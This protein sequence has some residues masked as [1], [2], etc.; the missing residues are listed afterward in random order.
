MRMPDGSEW[1]PDLRTMRW[2][3]G[4]ITE[5]EMLES[6]RTYLDHERVGPGSEEFWEIV[7]RG[8]TEGTVFVLLERAKEWGTVFDDVPD[9]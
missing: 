4:N 7:A 3:F 5:P 2:V 1:A 6:I 8:A 9:A